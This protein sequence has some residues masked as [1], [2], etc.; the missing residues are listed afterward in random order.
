MELNTTAIVTAIILSALGGSGI[1]GLA[2]W[3][4]KRAITRQDEALTKTLEDLHARQE[5][6][7][8]RLHKI[9]TVELPKIKTNQA[10][11][12]QQVNLGQSERG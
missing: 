7:G 1:M 11:L 3:W 5:E 4:V 8:V 12:N 2:F 6:H 9:E 10:L